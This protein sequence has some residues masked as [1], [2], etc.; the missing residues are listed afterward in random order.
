MIEVT[1][2]RKYDQRRAGVEI[3]VRMR[4]SGRF[5]DALGIRI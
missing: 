3:G 1:Q 5:A 2:K 4:R